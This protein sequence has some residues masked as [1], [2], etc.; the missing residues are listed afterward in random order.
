MPQHR[1]AS[2]H[3]VGTNGKTSVARMTAALLDAHGIRSGAYV[4]PH[5]L[6]WSER[7]VIGGEPIT[8]AAFEQALER[9]EEA[10]RVADRSAGE[11]GPVT[12]FELLTAAAFVAL[13]AAR[14]EIGVIEAGLGGRLDATNV[15]PSRAT[16]LTSVGL[17]HTEHLGVTLE[18][19]AA[20]KLAVLRD[21][22][23]LVH[24]ELPAAAEAVAEREA[25]VHHAR[26]LVSGEAPEQF[27]AGVPGY[28]RRNLG[29]ALAATQAVAGE[30]EAS[31]VKAAVAS[32]PLP[33]RVQLLPGD[34]P[35]ILDA[36][37]NA[38][39]ARALAEALPELIAPAERVVCCLAVLEGKDAE[40]IAGALAPLC[41]QV[42]CTAVPESAIA[43]GGRPGTSSQP[44][45]RLAALFAER[46]VEAA[47]E[48][49]LEAAVAQAR[50]AA[51]ER[52]LPMLVTGSHFLIGSVLGALPSFQADG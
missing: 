51:R 44:P 26:T 21:R 48:P 4:S 18:E 20:E 17:D 22:S 47:S 27:T 49:G 42:V 14:V 34:P 6:S 9:A 8:E 16:V 37:H 23:V 33:G 2:I 40:A 1:F 13:A 50:S 12:Q 30:L 11:E 25:A 35:V 45:E 29:L 38:D 5:L 52:E 28:Q 43:A 24:G 31:A 7:I 46:G 3:V 19:I 10:A 36:A 15:L 41:A 39:G 32:L